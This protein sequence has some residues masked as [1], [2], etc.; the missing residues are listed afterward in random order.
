MLE[1]QTKQKPKGRMAVTPETVSVWVCRHLGLGDAEDATL[2]NDP[3]DGGIHILI[4][5][6]ICRYEEAVLM[7]QNYFADKTLMRGRCSVERI[8]ETSTAIHLTRNK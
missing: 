1:A 8:T 2:V 5:T 4:P 7:M 3:T 6:R